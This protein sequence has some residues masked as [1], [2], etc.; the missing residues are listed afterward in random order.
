MVRYLP[1]EEFDE[2]GDMARRMGFAQVASGPFV[3]SSY[4]ARDMAMASD[5]SDVEPMAGEGRDPMSES[6]TGRDRGVPELGMP[7]VPIVVSVWLVP[8]GRR[9]SAG[10]SRGRTAGRRCGGRSL[11]AG[12]RR[13]LRAARTSEDERVEPGQVLGRSRNRAI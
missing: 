1:P 7:D 4:H 3:R 2:L 12:E 11:G 5:A 8:L 13:V 10:R 6:P 9:V